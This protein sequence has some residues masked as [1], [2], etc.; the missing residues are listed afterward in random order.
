MSNESKALVRTQFLAFAMKAFAE[1]NR[2]QRMPRY[3]FLVLLA[4][5]LA[6]VATGE[7]KRLVVNL[8]PRHFKTFLGAIALAA[9][10]LAHNPSA[11]I[12]IVTYGQELADKT[13]YAIRDILMADWF[14]RLFQGTRLAKNRTKLMDYVTTAGGGV[15][16]VSIEGGVT[17]LGADVIIVDDAVQIKDCDNFGHLERVNELFDSLIMTRLNRPK[18]G[19]VVVIAHRVNECD[20]PGH[21]MAQGGWKPFR[22]A[23]IAMKARTYELPNGEIWERK[24]GEL[25][26]PDAFT[27]RDIAQL[28]AA[29]RPGFE[30]LQQQNPGGKANVRIKPEHFASFSGMARQRGEVIS[31]DPGQ[32]AGASSAYCVIQAWTAHDGT[33]YLVDQFRARVRYPDA[34]SAVRRFIA[35]HRPSVILIEDTG[36]GPAL[37]SEIRPQEGMSVHPIVPIEEK[38]ERLRR[39]A[40]Q[41]RAGRIALPADAGWREDFIAEA[42]LFPYAETDDQVDAMTQYLDWAAL[43]PNPPKRPNRAV[44]AGVNAW[45]S[46]IT[47]L[48]SQ[49][50][51]LTSRGGVLVRGSRR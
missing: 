1:M 41:I 24:R 19:R 14:K 8:P 9:W 15:R 4:E 34:K 20:L 38:S 32:K 50:G 45:G 49:A 33:H 42:T 16:S 22:L 46:V 43:H 47:P 39:N 27:A 5:T 25:L 17:G 23:L 18:Q 12:L 36:Q 6:R 29:K 44:V 31:I 2:G 40:P 37:Q 21:L 30:T 28:R 13:A 3:P 11:K 10:I 7:S 26:R 35:R 51:M 48:Y